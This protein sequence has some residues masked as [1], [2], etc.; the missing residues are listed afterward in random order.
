MT[1]ITGPLALLTTSRSADIWPAGF[2]AGGAAARLFLLL[3]HRAARDDCRRADD[4]A[5]HHE[6][7][8][9]DAGR[10]LSQP[11]YLAGIETNPRRHVSQVPSFPLAAVISESPRRRLVRRDPLG[12]RFWEPTFPVLSRQLDAGI[13]WVGCPSRLPER[14]AAAGRNSIEWRRTGPALA[15]YDGNF[16][17]SDVCHPG[18]RGAA[19]AVGRR[20]RGS[21]AHRQ[22]Q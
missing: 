16:S 8:A 12:T 4:G 18:R 9:V 1:V 14:A 22:A 5:A 6:G 21:H 11:G 19:P 15:C 10:R 13:G 3:L 20:E 17:D 2:G 7:P